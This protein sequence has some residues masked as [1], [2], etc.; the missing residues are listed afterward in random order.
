MY[1]I[2]RVPDQTIATNRFMT[3]L[4]NINDAGEIVDLP[5]KA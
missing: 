4:L 2:T 3:D 5:H 1:A